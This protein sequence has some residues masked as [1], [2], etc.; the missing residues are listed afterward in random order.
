MVKKIDIII[1][2]GG[3]G[4]R[5]RKMGYKVPKYMIEAKGKTLF[6]WSL[7]SLEGYAR[8]A[9]QYIFIAMRDEKEDVEAFIECQCK[10]LGLKN[11][12]VILLD[13]LTD[14]QATTASL[15]EKYWNPDNSL[16]IYNIDTYVE[17]G[18]MNSAELKGDGFIPCFQAE[19]DHWSFVR[20]DDKGKVAE[21]KEKKRISNYCTLGAYFFKSCQLYKDLYNEYYGK[22]QELVNGEKYVAPLYDY[23]LSKGGEIYISDIAPE[24]V[25]VLGTPE[26]LQSFLCK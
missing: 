7:M 24:K 8:D 19:G 10:K 17:P 1:T 22:T 11:Y 14:G 13:Y 4:A 3:L 9:E 2:M 6:E 16:L 23:L 15:A 12:H 5:F 20:L 26:E 21:I 25:H 18:E